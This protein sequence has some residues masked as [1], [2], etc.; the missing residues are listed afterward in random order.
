MIWQC[1]YSIQGVYRGG[2]GERRAVR[3]RETGAR[4]VRC[5]WPGLEAGTVPQNHDVLHPRRWA[6]AGGQVGAARSPLR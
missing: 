5:A 4:T 1:Q 6:E 2:V 3:E